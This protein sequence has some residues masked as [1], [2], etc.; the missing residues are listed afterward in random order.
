L[1]P[2]WLR[3]FHFVNIIF[4]TLLIRSGIEILSAHPKLY[5]ND[6]ATD[7]T[8]WIKLSSKKMPKNKLW[9]STDEEEAFSSWIALPGR[10][11]L[12]LGRCWHFFS[13]I[14]WVANGVAYWA[15]LFATGEWMRLIPTSW[16]IFP[17]AWHTAM[18]YASGHL[19]PPGSP[20]N[21]LQQLTYAAV[22][23]ILGPFLGATGAAMSPAVGATF[24]WYPRIFKGRQVARSLHFLSLLAIVLFII[25][26]ISLVLL[27]RFPANMT[28]IV[29]GSSEGATFR[30]AVILFGIFVAVVIIV[31][32]WATEYSLLRPRHVQNMLGA[33]IEPVAHVLFLG[34]VSRQ[35]LRRSDITPY[36]RV[37][38]RPPETNEY[39][40]LLRNN[41][42]DWRLKVY[43]L[44]KNSLEL[45]LDDL[46]VMPKKT[47]ITEHSCIQGWTAIGEWE[48]VQVSEILRRCQPLPNARY[49]VFHSLAHGEKDEYGHGDPSG[50]YYEVIDLK[51]A[52]QY[53]TIVAFEMNREPLPVSHGAPARLRV[54]TQLG[55][56]MVKWLRSIELVEDYRTIGDGKGGYRED[57]QQYGIGASI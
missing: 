4:I 25:G 54:E 10:S 32:G 40:E 55:Y 17:E 24:P 26:H 56:K 41:F 3:V 19:P 18:I 6:N 47:Q 36:F 12:G 30:V 37:N 33:V 22:V 44:V 23:F 28:N 49:A 45:S 1:F 34:A 43:G 8:E 51:L 48:G 7:G 39:K 11:H 13:I 20:Y 57:A 9:T 31:H 46:H 21:P 29:F 52:N 53:Q 14:F 5:T 35:S 42:A 27:E 16:S 2:L 50:E 15:L 38:G